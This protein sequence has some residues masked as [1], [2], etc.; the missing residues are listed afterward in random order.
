[1]TDNNNPDATRRFLFVLASSRTGGNTETLTSRAAEALPEGTETRWLH[2]DDLPLD[3]FEDLRHGDQRARPLP[4]GDERT[5]LD[6]TLA[7]T[8]IV[9]ASPLY[10]YSVS[11]SAKLYLDYWTNWMHSPE[12]KFKERMRGKTLW[13]VCVLSEENP[14]QADALALTLRLTAEYLHMRWGGVLLGYGNRP[15]DIDRDNEALVRAKT[16]FG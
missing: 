4:T 2:L 14:A 16:F 12:L 11:A 5:L 7:A 9:I 3:R 13:G 1:M 6:A 8:D 10:W 15:G